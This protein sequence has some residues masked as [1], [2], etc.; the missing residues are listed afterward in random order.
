MKDAASGLRWCV[1]EMERRYKLMA[2]LGV[3]N[4][5]GY[6]RKIEDAIKAGEP[7]TDPLWT[8]NPDEMG[9]D[10]TQEAPEAPTLETLPYIVVVI[11]E[12]ADMMMIVGKKVEQLIARI[13]QKGTCRRYPS[14]TRHSAPVGGRYHRP[15][16]SQRTHQNRL[17]SLLKD[18]LKN[19]SRPRRRRTIT[20]QRRYALSAAGNQRSRTYSRL[21]CRRP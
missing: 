3:R 6:N 5:A 20:R 8:F 4:L 12:F 18:R 2:A 11:D 7:I 17:P 9:W 15:D 14:N 13:A 10:A 16:Q 1:G 21:F 19:H